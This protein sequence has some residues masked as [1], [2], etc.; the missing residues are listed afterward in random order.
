VASD[1]F[2]GNESGAAGRDDFAGLVAD[3]VKA[4]EVALEDGLGL[5][6]LG[7]SMELSLDGPGRFFS[8]FVDDPVFVAA[9]GDQAAGTEEAKVFGDLHLR[10]VQD[11]LEMADAEGALQEEVQ[12]A[13]A[14]F[15]RQQT[16]ELRELHEVY[17]L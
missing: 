4:F 8:E 12:E 17:M 5:G 14:G 13:Q 11:V 6:G 16:V 10:G 3:L 9:I 2:H 7:E 15:I 1:S